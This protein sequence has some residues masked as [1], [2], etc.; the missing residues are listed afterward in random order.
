MKK[1]TAVFAAFSLL[2][3]QGTPAYAQLPRKFLKSAAQTQKALGKLSAQTLAES[4][5]RFTT[6]V[7]TAARNALIGAAPSFTDLTLRARQ[8]KTSFL[9]DAILA[10]PV[11]AERT[12][13]LRRSFP[14][15]AAAGEASPEQLEQAVSFWRREL[16]RSL[17]DFSNTDELTACQTLAEASALGLFG[18]SQ[19]MVLLYTLIRRAEETPWEEA[20]AVITARSLLSRGNYAELELFFKRYPG[21]W[22]SLQNET[23]AY[24]QARRL[25]LQIETCPAQAASLNAGLREKLE[26]FGPAAPLAADA[27]AAA[28]GIWMNMAKGKARAAQNAPETGRPVPGPRLQTPVLEKGLAS[29]SVQ[30][31]DNLQIA[32]RDLPANGAQ[33]AV[34]AANPAAHGANPPAASVSAAK[35]SSRS[36]IMYGGIPLPE[37]WQSVK[38]AGGALLNLFKR[39]PAARTDGGIFRKIFKRATAEQGPVSPKAAALQRASLYAA[40]FVMGLEV[41][42][43]VLANFGS[44]FGLSLEENILVMAATYLPYSLGAFFSNWMK[45]IL[46]RKQSMNLGLSLM[47][48]GLGA[49]VTLCGLNGA[50][51]PE[52][53]TM[54]HFYKILACITTASLGGVLVHNSVGP[55]MTEL[56]ANA[57]ELVRQRRNTYTEFS[58]ALGMAASFAF[59]FLSTKVLGM[60]WSLTF[61][62][63]IPLVA[64][65]F[66]G[67]NLAKLPNTK[68]A[69]APKTKNATEKGF[70]SRLKNNEYIRLF[71]EEKGVGSFLSGLFIMN[72]VEMAVNSGFLF[73]L[74]KL[75]NDPSSQ[76]LFGLAQFAAP[77]LLGRYLA[78]K[79]LKWFPKHNMSA[80][81]LLAAGGGIASLFALDN[82]YALTAALFAAETGI[83]T[84][85][86][87][88]F[89]RTAKNSATQD[90][91]VS[92]IVAS[93]LSCAFGPMLLSSAAQAMIDA[94]IFSES[95]ATAAAMIGIPSGLAVLAAM[96]F[97]KVE[98]LGEAGASALKKLFSFIKKSV[99]YPKQRR[100]R[101]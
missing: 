88:G 9:A 4:A 29:V 40:S 76:Y 69:A 48:L 38:K 1:L 90:R 20:A 99:Y 62:L 25:P 81:T 61:A 82:V 91:V 24:A 100:K 54:A 67:V 26:P 77:F 86:T 30:T 32:L 53:D 57:G 27:S 75:T 65:A 60:D 50:F 55:M 58:R 74:P 93:A 64:G 17:P 10:H 8:G 33:T 79:S 42:T 70:L 83:S 44:S 7:R 36:G 52:P 31:P 46:G 49:G 43:P 6:P 84:G 16:I 95:A 45:K 23:A 96:L 37:M 14:A 89:A 12:E 41:A 2:L 59:P 15:A 73:L 18:N 28:T 101:T 35:A 98:N 92:L 71:K 56:S 78:A 80:A 3:S 87:L 68:P 94:G 19:D 39:K 63:P 85:F 47:G 66:L 21:R 5:G 51:L 34:P 13:L 11:P 97:R 22:P 72:G